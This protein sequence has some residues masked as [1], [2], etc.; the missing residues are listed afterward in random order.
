MFNGKIILLVEKMLFGLHKTASGVLSEVK[1]PYV[2][3][4][5]ISVHLSVR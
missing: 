5:F 2:K 3:S 1:K 4:E